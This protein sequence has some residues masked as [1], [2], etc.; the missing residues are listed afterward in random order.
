M[1]EDQAKERWCPFV[2]FNISDDGMT[3]PNRSMNIWPNRQPPQDDR[4]SAACIGSRCMA[5]RWADEAVLR[6][7]PAHGHCGLAGKS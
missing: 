2:R 3:S 6:E 1:T 5:W 4:R 7:P